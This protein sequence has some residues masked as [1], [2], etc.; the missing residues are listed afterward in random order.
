V[1]V[2]EFIDLSNKSGSIN[3]LFGLFEK[4]VRPMGI[5][6]IV[7][8]LM[9]DHT[10]LNRHAGHGILVN[11]PEGWMQ[12]Y[13][14]QGYESLDPVRHRMF[15]SNGPFE[16]DEL[17]ASPTLTNRQKRFFSE[18]ADA[19][20]RVGFG[21]P[22]RGARGAIAGFGLASSSRNL[23]LDNNA[24]SRMN[25]LA[26]QFYQAYLSLEGAAD[27]AGAAT[28]S[29]REQEILKWCARGK[30]RWEIGRI[31][32][33]SEN[34]VNFHLRNI[35]RKFDTRNITVAVLTALRHGLIQL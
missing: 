2:E 16:W 6:Q 9:T 3:E 30:T 12:Y 23:D 34:T 21:I 31:L 26:Q 4:A 29:E 24:L 10:A 5:D 22:L 18:A 11:Y 15:A 7:F 28:L 25:L 35:Y 27:D 8:S 19:G 14:E 32:G 17:V 33:V 20:L 13:A 1:Y